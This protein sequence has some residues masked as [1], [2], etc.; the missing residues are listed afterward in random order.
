MDGTADLNDQ[1]R[2][3]RDC[4]ELYRDVCEWTVRTLNGPKNLKFRERQ[5]GLIGINNVAQLCN[6]GF[7]GQAYAFDSRSNLVSFPSDPCPTEQIEE[8]DEYEITDLTTDVPHDVAPDDEFEFYVKARIVARP[9]ADGEMAVSLPS[10]NRIVRVDFSQNYAPWYRVCAAL[11]LAFLALKRK[12]ESSNLPNSPF[13]HGICDDGDLGQYIIRHSLRLEQFIVDL[14]EWYREL[15]LVLAGLRLPGLTRIELQSAGG[16]TNARPSNNHPG[17]TKAVRDPKGHEI[18]KQLLDCWTWYRD[19]RKR[20]IKAFRRFCREITEEIV[21][22]NKL[23]ASVD[24]IRKWGQCDDKE[25]D[26]ERAEVLKKAI[27]L[28]RRNAANAKQRQSNA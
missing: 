4:L 1:I 2:R 18:E 6:A 14:R 16:E 26:P 3:S 9:R 5:L 24:T 25:D 13:F 11:R 19:K 17:K 20:S 22:A 23:K 10:S 7:P 27:D 12:T 15:D 8:D 21:K 28:A